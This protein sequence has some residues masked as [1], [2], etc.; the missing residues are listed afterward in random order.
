MSSL[1]TL[2]SRNNLA[3]GAILALALALRLWWLDR[4]GFGT[5]Y[6]SAAV[7]S[8]L[9][10]WHNFFF[11]SFDPA[12]YVSIDKPPLTF[13]VQ[14]ASGWLF[15][16][17][18][19]SILVPQALEGLASVLILYH[20]V[21]RRFGAAAALVAALL[22]AITPV[23]VAADRSSN[24]ESLLILVL[25][26]AAWALIRATERGSARLL[27]LSLALV[28]VAFNIKMAVAFVLAPVLVLIY[29]VGAP[30]PLTRRVAQLGLAGV[31]ALV[32]SL[33]WAVAYDIPAPADRPF[34]G[35][36]KTNSMVELAVWGNGLDRFRPNEG[37][38]R[39]AQLAQQAPAATTD[40]NG[41]AP[42]RARRM[43]DNVPA[44]PLRL[45]DRHLAGQFAWWLP[46][47]LIGAFAAFARAPLRRPPEPTQRDVALWLGWA[48]LYGAVFSFDSGIFHAYYLSLLAPP[49]A[50]LTGIGLVELWRRYRAGTLLPS[51][52][53]GSLLL[54]A[55]IAA[56]AAWQIYLEYGALDWPA[57]GST[58]WPHL[59][60]RAWL[61]AVLAI[62]ALVSCG[63]LIAAREAAPRVAATALAIGAIALLVTPAAWALSP[64]LARNNAAMP[65]ADI[66]LLAG[67]DGRAG[68]RFWGGFG[69]GADDP[70]L[71]AFLTANRG[72]ARYLLATPNA[73]L[74]A[75]LI[76]RTGE[77]VMAVGGFSGADQ[78]LTREAF[79]RLVEEGQVRFVMINLPDPNARGADA[80]ANGQ[81]RG[82]DRGQG[83]AAGQGQ[84]QSQ[85][86]SQ[87]QSPAQNQN[88]NQDQTQAQNQGRAARMQRM[89][90]FNA[91]IQSTGHMV[92]PTLWRSE[93]ADGASTPPRR[94]GGQAGR[95]GQGGQIQLFDLRPEVGLNPN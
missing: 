50:A 32:V 60:W 19:L 6:Y 48:L 76:I 77:P 94:Q 54:P 64:V 69:A 46:F 37:R 13:W 78:I 4:N 52:R 45:A 68:R 57:D 75:P 72:N 93:P 29:F 7:R 91:M 17:S 23:S 2:L 10:S 56:T 87:V 25:L 15:G 43:F 1:K 3:L 40:G 21:Q 14:A 16:Y 74:A 18:G 70:K 62:G 89:A 8:M 12:G 71:R 36:T 39:R 47:A 90:A 63:G 51:H 33:S 61:F 34:A 28:G 80:S 35:G 20:L 73:R 38:I 58:P 31:V 83:Q 30:V 55:A 44:G 22:L 67:T 26:C 66:A 42:Q 92:D 27:V 88:Q 95:W 59:D 9:M 84:N 53:T 41:N 24:T 85:D 11:N 65:N 5:E 49:L 79:A 81:D 86:Q 82:Q